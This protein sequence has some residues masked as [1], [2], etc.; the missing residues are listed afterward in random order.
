[1]FYIVVN[2][3]I[4]GEKR[5]AIFSNE[6]SAIQAVDKLRNEFMR[7]YGKDFFGERLSKIR[8]EF[9]KKPIDNGDEKSTKDIFF[10][11]TKLEGETFYK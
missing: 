11:F 2:Q 7:D 1:M 10:F 6:I 4:R 3:R 8:L 5:F 9:T